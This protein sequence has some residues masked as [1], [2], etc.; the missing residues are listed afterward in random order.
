MPVTFFP[1][2]YQ[3]VLRGTKQS[4]FQPF[5]PGVSLNLHYDARIFAA[6]KLLCYHRRN[7]FVF[8]SRTARPSGRN[9]VGLYEGGIRYGGHCCFQYMWYFFHSLP[10]RVGCSLQGKLFSIFKLL[11]L[12]FFRYY[13]S[14]RTTLENCV[15]FLIALRSSWENLFAD[16]RF[17]LLTRA[18]YLSRLS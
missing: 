4:P 17:V 3:W 12:V 8:V 7:L 11:C 5:S 18:I 15:L 10:S 14:S 16:T 1:L 2:Y 6:N 9:L 13:F